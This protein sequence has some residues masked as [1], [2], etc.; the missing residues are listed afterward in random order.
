MG[1]FTARFKPKG[2]LARS[3]RDWSC[4]NLGYANGAGGGAA[5]FDQGVLFLQNTDQ[6]GR[7]LAVYSIAVIGP[8]VEVIDIGFAAGATL[9]PAQPSCFPTKSDAPF[10]PGLSDYQINPTFTPTVDIA[11]NYP[12]GGLFLDSDDPLWLIAPN[13]VFWVGA[14]ESAASGLGSITIGFAPY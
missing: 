4:E 7:Y 5:P 14:T 10:P 12:P 2:S 1:L 3:R 13:D 9:N 11:W 6:S 8:K